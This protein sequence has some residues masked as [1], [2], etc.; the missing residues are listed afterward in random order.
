MQARSFSFRRAI[1]VLLC[2]ALGVPAAYARQWHFDVAA[3]GIRLGTYSI[4][5]Q[6]SGDTA[7]ATSEINVGV[8][9]IGAYR[10][11]AEETWKGGCLSRI[12]TRTEEHGHV[13][14]LSGQREGDV[15]RIAGGT[16]ESHPGCVMTFAYWNPDVLKQSHL[17]NAQTGAWTPVVVRDLGKDTLAVGGKSVEAA[18]Y[19]IDTASNTIEV[20]YSPQGEWLSLKTTT[21]GGRH[22]LAY[23]LRSR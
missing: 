8:L 22:V 2:A 20:W 15:F 12:A 18:H 23:Q 21:K 5:V 10:Q 17:V 9:G 4:I 1:A 14:S 13:T 7:V 19:S 3:D 6:E 11:R 16:P